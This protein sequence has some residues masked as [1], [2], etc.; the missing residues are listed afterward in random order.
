MTRTRF[1]YCLFA[2]RSSSEDNTAFLKSI[3]FPLKV[4]G[5]TAQKSQSALEKKLLCASLPL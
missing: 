4:L 2:Y 5:A 3:G 1:L